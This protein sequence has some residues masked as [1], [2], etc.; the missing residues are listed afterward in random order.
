MEG[1]P[2]G[3]QAN[4]RWGSP[5]NK[6]PSLTLF[7]P[8]RLL[9]DPPKKPEGSPFK[10]PLH[11][12]VLGFGAESGSG[13]ANR[14]TQPIGEEESFVKFTKCQML[15]QMLVPQPRQDRSTPLRECHCTLYRALTG[16]T[17]QLAPLKNA[18]DEAVRRMNFIKSY[19]V[20]LFIL[21]CA[22]IGSMHRALPVHIE[23]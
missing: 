11:V 13:G 6:Y 19:P 8:S 12:S 15:Y 22:E 10:Q 1:L 7:P 9:L 4:V 23:V 2:D 20:I 21:L 3:M 18:F 17:N 5:R 14:D 16:E